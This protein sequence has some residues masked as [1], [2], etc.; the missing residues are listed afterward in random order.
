M[1]TGFILNLIEEGTAHCNAMYSGVAKSSLYRQHSHD[2]ITKMSLCDWSTNNSLETEE[3]AT[4]Q[5]LKSIYSKEILQ[6]SF[7]NICKILACILVC[8]IMRN[9]YRKTT[10]FLHFETSS[11]LILKQLRPS[12]TVTDFLPDLNYF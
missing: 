11:K 5:L 7:K 6:I 4:Y 10:F 9:L 8:T 12:E 1:L 3:K 2:D